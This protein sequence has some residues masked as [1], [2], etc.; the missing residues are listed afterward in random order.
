MDEILSQIDDIKD[1][2]T[3]EEYRNLCDS[4]MHIRNN[5]DENIVFT[6]IYFSFIKLTK[7]TAEQRHVCGTITRGEIPTHATSI[8]HGTIVCKITRDCYEFW[9]S[10]IEEHP[11]GFSIDPL[12]CYEGVKELWDYVIAHDGFYH[13]YNKKL[14]VLNDFILINKLEQLR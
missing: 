9:K 5:S 13:E 7:P 4:C 12:F 10:K 8:K 11:H 14:R 3:S 1:K 2:L 6:R